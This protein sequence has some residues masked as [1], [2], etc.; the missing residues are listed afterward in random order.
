MQRRSLRD[1]TWIP[2][3]KARSGRRLGGSHIPDLDIYYFSGYNCP[4][5]W[6]SRYQERAALVP[7]GKDAIEVQRMAPQLDRSSLADTY[8]PTHTHTRPLSPPTH[9]YPGTVIHTHSC[10]RTHTY[11]Q[12]HVQPHPP[13]CS[14]GHLHVLTHTFQLPHICPHTFIHSLTPP[15]PTHSQNTTP[16]E[17]GFSPCD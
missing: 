1:G 7:E 10:I 8:G 4:G 13:T 15:P 3:H 12:S 9:V 16:G 11:T 17:V 5:P 14:H 2:F 6:F